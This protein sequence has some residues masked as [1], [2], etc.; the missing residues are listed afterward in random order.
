MSRMDTKIK[1]ALDK[2]YPR[3]KQCCILYYLKGWTQFKIARYIKTS[4]PNVS[5]SIKSGLKRAKN[6][7]DWL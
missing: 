5:Q 4:Q 3:Q 6:F 7:I 1:D 2:M